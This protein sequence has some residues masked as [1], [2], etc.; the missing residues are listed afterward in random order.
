MKLINKKIISAI[1]IVFIITV[2]GILIYNNKTLNNKN[3]DASLRP[4]YHFTPKSN[5]LNDPNG[6]CYY[7]GT[8]HLYYQ[9]N[10]FAPC[11]GCMHW[12]HATSKDMLNW[13]YEEIALKYDNEY[14]KDGCFSGSAIEK[15]GKLHIFY[16]GVKYHKIKYNEYNIPIQEDP[17]GFTPSQ[18]HAVSEDGGYSFKKILPPSI[19]PTDNTLMRDPKVFKTKEGFYRMVLGDTEDYKKGS[20]VFYKSDD[21]NKW[22]FEGKWTSDKFGWGLG[23]S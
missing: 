5:W 7:N 2:I 17:N 12:G 16:T 18:I 22:E 10:P 1:F 6:L 13:K 19:M 15:D 20:L 14:D 23:M 3:F 21:L 8:F 11:W 4:K 9:Y